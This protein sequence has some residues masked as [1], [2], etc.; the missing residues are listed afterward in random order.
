MFLSSLK[1]LLCFRIDF[2]TYTRELSR[3]RLLY[4]ITR[5]SGW[6]NDLLDAPNFARLVWYSSSNLTS[7]NTHK[8]FQQCNVCK[9]HTAHRGSLERYC[10]PLLRPTSFPKGEQGTRPWL[11]MPI[12]I[13]SWPLH[14]DVVRT[15]VHNRLQHM[16]SL[17]FVFIPIVN[18]C[19]KAFGDHISQFKNT[20]SRQ[21]KR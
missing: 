18:G 16:L 12:I 19:V 17:F 2:V 9:L 4:C 5:D 15:T 7:S 13:A 6:S 20:N 1:A 8:H 11:R 21:W 10:A 3:K 14:D